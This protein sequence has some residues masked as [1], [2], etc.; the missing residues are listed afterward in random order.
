MPRSDWLVDEM[1]DARRNV[2][3]DTSIIKLS[4]FIVPP[5]RIFYRREPTCLSFIGWDLSWQRIQ[6]EGKELDN[7]CALTL[8]RRKNSCYLYYPQNHVFAIMLHSYILIAGVQW[9]TKVMTCASMYFSW[10]QGSWL[11]WT[12]LHLGQWLIRDFFQF[13]LV[14]PMN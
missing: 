7:T 2:Q 9:V 4:N 12:T 13:V 11:L 5:L 1:C 6:S 14:L 8:L 10:K 3:H